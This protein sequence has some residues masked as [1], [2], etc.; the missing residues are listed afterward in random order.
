[1]E[2]CFKEDS[3]ERVWAVFAVRSQRN[4]LK[5]LG[6]HM[7]L[8]SKYSLKKFF[9]QTLGGKEQAVIVFL[10]TTFFPCPIM[11]YTKK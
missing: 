6:K 7:M 10:K 5:K 2:E 8:L 3:W 1:M 9:V 11:L 4:I